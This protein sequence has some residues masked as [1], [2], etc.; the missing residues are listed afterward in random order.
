MAQKTR[1]VMRRRPVERRNENA[2]HMGMD[3]QSGT[4]RGREMKKEGGGGHNWGN[5]AADF[6]GAEEGNESEEKKKGRSDDEQANGPSSAN[7]TQAEVLSYDKY[8][9]GISEKIHVAEDANEVDDEAEKQRYVQQGYEIYTKAA[10]GSSQ[11]QKRADNDDENSSRPKP[12]HLAELAAQSGVELRYGGNRRP[13]REN[14][15]EGGSRRNENESGHTTRE[16]RKENHNGK[17]SQQQ[18]SQAPRHEINL[19][20]KLAFPTLEAH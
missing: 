12:M 13:K 6:G 7:R 20:D 14:R 9:A 18:R 5:E 8:K 19:A 4:G 11:S 1:P 15:E 3:K 2:E 17:A 10:R 16:D